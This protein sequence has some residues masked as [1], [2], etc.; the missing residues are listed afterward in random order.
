MKTER[1]CRFRDH[2]RRKSTGLSSSW[3]SFSW[4]SGVTRSVPWP[5]S[6]IPFSE[7]TS[8]PPRARRLRQP[9]TRT[10]R[11]KD[12]DVIAS[13]RSGGHILGT[14]KGGD[15]TTGAL[16]QTGQGNQSALHSHRK[17]APLLAR[18]DNPSNGRGALR[19]DREVRTISV[20]N[21]EAGCIIPACHATPRREH[22]F[23]SDLHPQRG[24]FK[25]RRL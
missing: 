19:Q 25:R 23:P 15:R 17:S 2:N 12:R 21:L 8:C 4:N 24:R 10:K 5:R 20:E 18:G 7:N 3:S 11:L 1:P 16:A 22:E 13:C 9:P 14:C 6:W